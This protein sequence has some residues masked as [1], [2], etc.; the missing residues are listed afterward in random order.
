MSRIS[1]R[2]RILS[3]GL[4]VVHQQGFG[5]ASVRDIICAAGVPQGSFTNHFASK[6]AFGLEVLNLYYASAKAR[7]EATLLDE[8]LAPL[9]RMRKWVGEIKTA[10]GEGAAKIGCMLGNFSAEATNCD[11]CIR[12]RLA[13]IFDEMQAMIATCLE[14]AVKAGELP[15]GY[16]CG[17][18]AGFILSSMQGA[19]LLAKA[20]RDLAPIAQFEQVLFS[21][22]LV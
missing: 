13:E 4:H 3:E 14:A 1:N 2:D 7:M 6:E 10:I 18:T 12:K 19:I 15:A 22:V 8:S 16:N 11:G 9:M 21:K 20:H 17:E 5:G